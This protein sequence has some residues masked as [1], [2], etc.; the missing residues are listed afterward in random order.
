MSV[1]TCTRLPHI[2]TVH[3]HFCTSVLRSDCG[4]VR[5]LHATACGA[6]AYMCVHVRA[7]VHARLP[8]TS[9][10]TRQG[11]S[12]TKLCSNVLNWPF[13]GAGATL[14]FSLRACPRSLDAIMRRCMRRCI[15][16]HLLAQ[17]STMGELVYTYAKLTRTRGRPVQRF[18]ERFEVLAVR[19]RNR[20]AYSVAAPQSYSAYGLEGL[21]RLP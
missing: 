2:Y 13:R 4:E 7:P 6:Y 17:C 10:A 18:C 1:Y 20:G 3:V 21:A 14:N 12:S 11:T 5:R 15:S 9:H 16:L 19:P 8:E